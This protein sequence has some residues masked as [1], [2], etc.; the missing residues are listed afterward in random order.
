MKKTGVTYATMSA[1]ALR[2]TDLSET[3]STPVHV[4]GSSATTL[5]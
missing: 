2:I 4:Y 5:K 1:G 3:A